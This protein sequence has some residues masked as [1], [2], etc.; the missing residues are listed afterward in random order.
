MINNGWWWLMMINDDQWWLM[1]IDDG[2][3]TRNLLCIHKRISCVYAR[4]LLCMHNT[5]VHALGHGTQGPGTQQGSWA[6]PRLWT[7]AF[8][9]PRP[10]GSLAQSMHKSVVHAQE[11]SC[12][13][14]RGSF[15]YAQ[16][17]LLCIQE[18]SSVYTRDLCCI[19]KR[20]RVDTRDFLC[21]HKRLW[22]IADDL[23]SY[24]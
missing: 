15:V 16:E 14:T 1:M 10:L 3:R 13:Y 8:L 4:D 11:I 9:G 2:S 7:A 20:S 5:L 18:I 22:R 21:V 19:H 24:F 23:F 12:V 17:I 6:G